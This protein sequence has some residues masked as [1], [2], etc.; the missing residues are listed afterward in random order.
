MNIETNIIFMAYICLFFR[1]CVNVR[2][3]WSNWKHV[4]HGIGELNLPNMH[5]SWFCDVFRACLVKEQ[6]RMRE[7][8]V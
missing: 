1:Y 5:K 7:V 8:D 3:S 6:R 2:P 4:L